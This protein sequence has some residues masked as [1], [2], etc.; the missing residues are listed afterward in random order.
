MVSEEQKFGIHDQNFSSP[1]SVYSSEEVRIYNEYRDHSNLMNIA[2]CVPD[3]KKVLF[4]KKFLKSKW[5]QEVTITLSSTQ[6]IEGKVGAVGRDF[7]MLWNS[8]RRIWI[9]YNSIRS[10]NIPIGYPTYTNSHLYIL[11]DNRLRESLLSRFGETVAKRSELRNLFYEE[12]LT[13]HLQSIIGVNIEIRGEKQITGKLTE[14]SK[15]GVK[16][17]HRGYEYFIA[18]QDIK[19]IETKGFFNM[20]KGYVKTWMDRGGKTSE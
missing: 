17:R 11:Y 12:A 7:V 2:K 10:S 13:T 4:L 14:C 9:P 3:R 16:I 15:E 19:L 5:N 1:S 6:V 20:I 18:F 8:F